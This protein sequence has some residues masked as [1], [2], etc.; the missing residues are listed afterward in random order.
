MEAVGVELLGK[1][2][3]SCSPNASVFTSNSY[4]AVVAIGEYN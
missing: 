2:S 1:I 3:S 4:K